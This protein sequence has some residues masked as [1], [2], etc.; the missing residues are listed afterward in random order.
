MI[1]FASLSTWHRNGIVIIFTHDQRKD[2]TVH[3]FPSVG[4]CLEFALV[5]GYKIP[6]HMP[7]FRQWSPAQYG[8]SC[9]GNRSFKLTLRT[10]R[11]LDDT[12]IA[13]C[14]CGHFFV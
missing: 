9:I 6:E 7:W 4:S 3:D 14:K 8:H 13:F 10:P 11:K 12:H 1:L 5:V 2:G